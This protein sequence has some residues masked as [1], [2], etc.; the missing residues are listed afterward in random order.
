MKL[1][2]LCV[3]IVQWCDWKHFFSCSVSINAIENL[4]T[5]QSSVLFFHLESCAAQCLIDTLLICKV[6]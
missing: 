3:F 4:V 1:K 6:N 5:I 2:G